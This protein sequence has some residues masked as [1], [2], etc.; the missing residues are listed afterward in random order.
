MVLGGWRGR[1]ELLAELLNVLDIE[2]GHWER[3]LQE[4]VIGED[5]QGRDIMIM[6][7]KDETLTG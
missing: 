2:D 5:L 6:S 4:Q 7:Y 3:D 1:V